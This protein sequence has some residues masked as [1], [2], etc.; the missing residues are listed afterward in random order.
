MNNM[1]DLSKKLGPEGKKAFDEWNNNYVTERGRLI[2]TKTDLDKTL[3][4]LTKVIEQGEKGLTRIRE[5]KLRVDRATQNAYKVLEDITKKA[6]QAPTTVEFNMQNPNAMQALVA[7]L[8]N[9]DLAG[10]NWARQ[11]PVGQTGRYID[12]KWNGRSYTAEL[13]TDQEQA[14][15]SIHEHN[16]NMERAKQG[17]RALLAEINRTD[18]VTQIGI[19]A[20]L[21]TFNN[22]LAEL[23]PG[24]VTQTYLDDIGLGKDASPKYL[25]APKGLA[26]VELLY[27]PE[28]ARQAQEKAREEQRQNAEFD[29]GVKELAKNIPALKVLMKTAIS[30]ADASASGTKMNLLENAIAQN[31]ALRGQSTERIYN[32]LK[33]QNGGK[34]ITQR[35]DFSGSVMVL[36]SS[37]NIVDLA[38]K[39]KREANLQGLEQNTDKLYK[40]LL[41]V[42]LDPKED[43]KGVRVQRDAAKAYLDQAKTEQKALQNV[44]NTLRASG[45]STE[46]LQSRKQDL[47]VKVTNAENF[48]RQAQQKVDRSGKTVGELR[49]EEKEANDR[50]LLKKKE[51]FLE[52]AKQMETATGKIETRDQR[53][54][55]RN[56]ATKFVAA[57]AEMKYLKDNA[58][59]AMSFE[60]YKNFGDRQ[61]LQERYDQ[62]KK[63]FDPND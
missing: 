6:E 50:K 9:P 61:H 37:L 45:S 28:L 12:V 60:G 27:K 24:T 42:Q 33:A 44:E 18:N 40:A 16:E 57:R 4:E 34:D 23:R 36:D 3:T 22:L 54:G 55:V 14:S 38:D 31:P 43:S 46:S 58:R 63:V 15:R 26:S 62:L 10:L 17:A 19:D 7:A 52:K 35:N 56:D 13:T 32:A 41:R 5:Q 59:D 48:F 51:D 20:A 39:A 25:V 49:Q 8:N 21:K 47:Q 29:K 53:E 30:S 1:L 2:E 11:W